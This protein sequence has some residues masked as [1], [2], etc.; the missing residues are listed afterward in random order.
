M[1]ANLLKPYLELANKTRYFLIEGGRGSGKS[2]HVALFLLMLTYKRGH[3]ILFTRYTM[4]SAII[5]IIKE[6]TEKIDLYANA[7][8][9]EIKQNEITNNLT[10]ST[11]IFRGIKNSSGNQTANLKSILSNV[12]SSINSSASSKTHVV[13]P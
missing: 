10:G 4:T 13:T 3:V 11:I 2:F 6:F 12:S 7:E 1:Q 9:F 8:H 5:S